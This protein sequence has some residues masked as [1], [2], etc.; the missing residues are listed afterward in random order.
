MQKI[1]TTLLNK[2]VF[3]KY[4]SRIQLITETTDKDFYLKNGFIEDGGG[5]FKIKR[6]FIVNN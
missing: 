4:F 3:K 1:G 6:N 2:I 5:I